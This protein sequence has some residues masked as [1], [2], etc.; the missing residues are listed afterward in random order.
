MDNPEI[1]RDRKY[2]VQ[3][4]HLVNARYQMNLSEM[5]LFIAVLSRI[6]KGDNDF[7]ELEIPV[8]ELVPGNSGRSYELVRDACKSMARKSIEIESLAAN[9]LR[10]FITMPLLSICQYTEKSGF[11]RIQVNEKVRPYL[12][13]LSANFTRAEIAH[14]QSLRSFYAFRMYWLLKQYQKIGKR[15][16]E[17]ETL[18]QIFNAEDKYLVFS[19]FNRWVIKSAQKELSHTDVSFTY[20]TVKKGRTV[21]EIIFHIGK[22]SPEI[23][24]DAPK[25]RKR[26]AASKK[27]LTD[28]PD[29]AKELSE[30]GVSPK[31]LRDLRRRVDEGTLDAEYIRFC[32]QRVSLRRLEGDVRSVS[33]LLYRSISEGYWQE[34]FESREQPAPEPTPTQATTSELTTDG[35]VPVETVLAHAGFTPDQI[36]WVQK[37]VSP[38]DVYRVNYAVQCEGHKNDALRNELWRQL[39]SRARK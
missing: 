19:Q 31:S 8:S 23:Q 39:K 2:A 26:K 7:Q 4:N 13:N 38:A 32:I 33:G 17:V 25:S 22:D 28:L 35:R 5:R 37:H 20:E 24:S 14:L 34:E 27:P 9:N 30:L 6:R 10:Q 16:L 3:H 21:H 18:R 1:H 11:V 12:L 15:T 36:A 29:W